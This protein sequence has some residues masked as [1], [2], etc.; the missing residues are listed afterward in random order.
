MLAI[1]ANS[2][3]ENN[4]KRDAAILCGVFALI[5]IMSPSSALALR[6]SRFITMDETWYA[7][8]NPDV[9]TSLATVKNNVP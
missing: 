5:H 9:I 3:K 6:H 1:L 8:D 7:A 2:Q 4:M